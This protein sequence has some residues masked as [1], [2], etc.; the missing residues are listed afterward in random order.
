M[1]EDNTRTFADNWTG[2]GAIENADDAERLALDADEYM[3]S[4]VVDTSTLTVELDYNHYAA[5]DAITLLYRDGAT[6]VACLAADW[7]DYTVP[8]M[9]L[10]F[11]QI[12]VEA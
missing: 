9:S 1:V 12:R 10:G 11:V 5:G 3:E 7:T 6:E 2:T 4:E 8:F